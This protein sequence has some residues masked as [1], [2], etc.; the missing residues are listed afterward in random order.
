M[1]ICISWASSW[2][3]EA[4]AKQYQQNWDT[5]TLTA[6]DETQKQKMQMDFPKADF[7]LVDFA[8]TKQVQDFANSVKKL[9]LDMFFMC[10]WVGTYTPFWDMQTQDIQS[11]FHVNMLAP[12]SILHTC[13]ESFL[14][15][16]TKVVFCSSV[17]ADFYAKNMS[18]Y[19]ASKKA[20]NQA[21]S[22]VQE[23]YPQL[24]ILNL[25]LWAVQTPMHTKVGFEKMQWKTLQKVIPRITMLAKKRSW[26]SYVFWDWWFAWNILAPLHRFY[27]QLKNLWKK[28]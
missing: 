22:I 17:V 16:H 20:L 15:N 23:E 24:R 4:L 12:L 5:L 21:L 7:F 25:H 28:F 13:K 27:I 8:N 6:R 1:N 26:E 19:S 3:W 2:I 11:Q 9:K 18:I 14:Q 10:A